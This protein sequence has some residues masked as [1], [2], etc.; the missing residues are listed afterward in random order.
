MLTDS[1]KHRN[2]KYN[3]IF[4]ST[5]LCHVSRKLNGTKQFVNCKP[6]DSFRRW[7]TSSV[8]SE[9]QFTFTKDTAEECKGRLEVSLV[10]EYAEQ[11]YH[12]ARDRF[13]RLS[14][15]SV[16]FRT[17]WRTAWTYPPWTT[18]NQPWSQRGVS[19]RPVVVTAG[20]LHPRWAGFFFFNWFFFYWFFV[21]SCDP[22]TVYA[23][24]RYMLDISILHCL[25]FFFFVEEWNFFWSWFDFGTC[26]NETKES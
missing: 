16:R 4:K 22:D 9:A 2:Q 26:L 5:P 1:K 19:G 3:A 11:R 10:L 18:R 14:H 8:C 24:V 13:I 12:A 20:S 7:Q 15:L 25:V 17:A 21:F 23:L 6:V